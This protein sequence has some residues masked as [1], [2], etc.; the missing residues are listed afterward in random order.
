MIDMTIFEMLPMVNI[1]VHYELDCD[2]FQLSCVM[3]GSLHL[4]TDNYRGNMTRSNNLYMSPPSGSRGSLIYFKDHPV[5]TV[6]FYVSRMEREV[7]NAVLGECGEELWETTGWD[8]HRMGILYPVTTSPPSVV[9]SFIQVANCNYPHR[10]RRLFFEN[11][12]R[13]ILTRLIAHELPDDETSAGMD[14]FEVERIKSIPG[15]LMER[16]DSPP[17]IPELARSLSISATRL[18]RGF[19]KIFGKPIYSYHRD[20]CL[21]RAAIIL[22]NTNRPILDIAADAGYSGSGNFCNAFKKHYGV[23]PSQYRR[24]DGLFL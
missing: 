17:S 4:L 6:S 22:L 23:S 3:A 21:E 9:N 24:K 14:K 19:K 11:A 8:K 10:A 5:K 15:I 20:I 13:E 7:M 12:F 18:T 2:Y 1:D 16:L